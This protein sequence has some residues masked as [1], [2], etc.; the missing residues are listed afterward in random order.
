VLSDVVTRFDSIKYNGMPAGRRAHQCC[1]LLCLQATAPDI[2]GVL[3]LEARLN[4]T[5]ELPLYL[6]ASGPESQ[7]FTAEFTPESPLNF[8]VLPCKGLLPPAAAD[9]IDGVDRQAAAEATELPAPLRVTFTC[10]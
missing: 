2:A 3:N 7:P 5:A 8:D 10:K 9:T 4:C 1:V 6:T